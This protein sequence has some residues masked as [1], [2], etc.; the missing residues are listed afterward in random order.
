MPVD[1][2]YMSADAYKDEGNKAFKEGKFDK[3]VTAYTLAINKSNGKIPTYFTNRAFAKLKSFK[4]SDDLESVIEDCS[5]V[6]GLEC[7]GSILMKAAYYTGLAQ[8][9]LGRPNEAYTSL[10]K[11]YRIAIQER[12]PSIGDVQEKMMEARKIRWER[13]EKVRIEEESALAV[14]LRALIESERQWR[15]QIAGDDESS[16]EEAHN[17]AADTLASLELLLQRSDE[18]FRVRE[19]PYHFICPLSL[20]L[21]KDPVITPSG[22]S[23]ERVAILQHLKHHPFEPLTRQPLIESKIFDNICLRDA[24]EEFVQH[25]GWAADY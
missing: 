4:D 22:R 8:L 16:I 18:R 9:E 13:S 21:F 25:N 10:V 20:S 15:L 11:A 2:R 17:D 5:R 1:V 24:C 12:S 19:V 23:Y 6:G 7:Q 3:A 14:K